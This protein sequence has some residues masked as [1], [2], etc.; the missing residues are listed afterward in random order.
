MRRSATFG[1]ALPPSLCGF[2][3]SG[4]AAELHDEARS[5]AA[6]LE[7]QSL[8]HVWALDQLI[9]RS[10]TP[11]PV[12]A[13][14]FLAA[15]TERVRLGIA[16][17][18][19]A[20]RGPLVAAK[21]LAT[22]DWLTAGR[23]EVGLGL[24]HPRHYPA[25]GLD[26]TSEDRPGRLL[27][28]IVD[29]MRQLWGESPVTGGDRWRFDET[30]M[31]PS[32]RQHGGPPLWFGGGGPWSFARAVHQ[33]VGWIGAGR[34]SSSEF[35]EMAPRVVEVLDRA[36]RDRSTFTMAKRVYLHV[37]PN[38]AVGERVVREWFDTF[39]GRAELGP[40]VTVT[41]TPDACAEQLRA[42]VEAGAD[43]LIVHP[44]VDTPEVYDRVL[45]EVVV[46]AAEL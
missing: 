34:H 30:R 7:H 10:P 36:G 1:I 31:Q 23:L 35:A 39:Y 43:H 14:S 26:S 20:S 21:S 3:R 24:G 33:G 27:D 11:E 46:P 29:A 6:L 40:D 19:P 5:W 8:T 15:F 16:I 37:E 38:P 4:T 42:L 22:L 9:G 13:L 17:L 2:G 45:N 12:A 18:V 32:P 44:L 41:G 25:Y 28:D